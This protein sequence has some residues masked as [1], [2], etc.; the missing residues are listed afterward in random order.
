MK[1]DLK[2][3]WI[4]ALRSGNYEQGTGDLRSRSG[5]FCCLGVLCDVMGA[6]WSGTTPILNGKDMDRE[7]ESFLSG[8]TLERV[9]FDN[10]TQIALARMND[11]GE[12]FGKIA[13]HIEKHL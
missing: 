2:A 10:E 9:G 3:K 8:D 5:Q 7:D 6:E 4:D 12:P 11:D 1:P 13:D